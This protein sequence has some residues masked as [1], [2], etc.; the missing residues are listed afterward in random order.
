M[1]YKQQTKQVHSC[2]IT[3]HVE[4][5]PCPCIE[6]SPNIGPFPYLLGVKIHSP[7]H[8]S[9][10]DRVVALHLHFQVGKNASH[11]VLV[12]HRVLV[13]QL[14][15]CPP[16]KWKMCTRTEGKFLVTKYELGANFDEIVMRL[17]WQTALICLNWIC[18]HCFRCWKTVNSLNRLLQCGHN[19]I[20]V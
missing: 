10:R 3:A 11:A 8:V 15:L 5:S 2:F 14:S 17:R 1:F 6:F 13:M 19:N 18:K 7:E 9:C 12:V 16:K 20:L 4:S